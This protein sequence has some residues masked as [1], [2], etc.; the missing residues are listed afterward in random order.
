[1]YLTE[2]NFYYADLLLE[3]YNIVELYTKYLY[4]LV[5]NYKN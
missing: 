1:M 3:K 4:K 2:N 5:V